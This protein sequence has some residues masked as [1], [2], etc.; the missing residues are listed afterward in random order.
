M[1][2]IYRFLQ[3]AWLGG[4]DYLNEHLFKHGQRENDEN[5]KDRQ[6]RSVY[7]NYVKPV[8]STYSDHTF[9]RGE[10]ITREIDESRYAS[11]TDNVDRRG[12]DAD[13]FWSYA[14]ER[15][16]LYGWCGIV[17]DMPQAP[18]DRDLSVADLETLGQLPYLIYVGPQNVVDWSVDRF[19]ALNWVRIRDFELEDTDPDQD[20]KETETFRIWGRDYWRVEDKDGAVIGAGDHALG[21][22]PFVP[23]RIEESD[24][25]ELA[26]VSFV[27]DFARMNR[28]VCN[29]VSVRDR[30]LNQNAFQILTVQV[31]SLM[32][33]P[34]ED[35]ARVM[36]EG[37]VYE[38]AEGQLPPGFISPD[39]SGVAQHLDHKRDL[40][41]EMFRMASIQDVRAGDDQPDEKSGVAKSIDFMEQNSALADFAQSV[42]NAELAATR[43]W[44]RWLGVPWND[45]WGI[46]YPD[47]FDV[48]AFNMQIANALR[49]R[50]IFGDIAPQFLATYLKRL[51]TRLVDDLDDD[52]MKELDDGLREK[53]ENIAA[54][55]GQSGREA[56]DAMFVEEDDEDEDQRGNRV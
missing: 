34:E 23:L 52:A 51:A 41:L 50:E 19:G 30:F 54:D 1:K 37:N 13:E 45:D 29:S 17:V 25:H 38:Y 32:A 21:V 46:E 8:V 33:A 11:W 27:Y 26:G 4:R 18:E 31:Q 49:V 16:L 5:W 47:D 20:R 12:K 28:M 6:K 48:Q 22:V 9:R 7:P 53:L 42:Q 39:V 14:G 36:R 2:D 43:L 15:A 56:R 10:G 35:E 40:I 44:A 55:A 24:A 3:L